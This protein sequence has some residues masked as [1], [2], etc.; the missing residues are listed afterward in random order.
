M[1]NATVTHRSKSGN[2]ALDDIF[3]SF[4]NG[5]LP[6]MHSHSIV[7]WRGETSEV[8]VVGTSSKPVSSNP[9][10]NSIVSSNPVSKHLL[11]VVCV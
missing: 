5:I 9:V 8:F 10:S 1:L 3:V 6:K 4:K 2:L 7:D 11:A